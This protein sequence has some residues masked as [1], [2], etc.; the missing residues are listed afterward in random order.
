MVKSGHGVE[1]FLWKVLSVV[2]S[3]QAVGVCRISDNQGFDVSG[4]VIVDCFTSVDENLAV[5]LQQVGSLH[6]RS[7]WLSSNKEVV[8][9]VLE[10]LGLIG[11]ADDSMEKWESTIVE[12]HLNA[13]ELG[14]K[15]G[16]IDQVQN[17]W[18]IRTEH[19]SVGDS[20]G[21]G[22]S[23]VA[24]S[25]GNGNSDWISPFALWGNEVDSSSE[26]VQSSC[27]HIFATIVTG[28]PFP[29]HCYR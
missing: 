15:S 22:I 12:F 13:L 27:Q 23:D 20:E 1:V 14:L 9:G 5:V 10:S 8:V 25:S 3:N 24:G 11:S 21:Y 26:S 19:F 16:D 28:R 17:N 4:R 7:S 29:N 6:S 18:L 2:G